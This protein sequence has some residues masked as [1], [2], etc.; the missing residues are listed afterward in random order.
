MMKSRSIRKREKIIKLKE[1]RRHKKK[2][3]SVLLFYFPLH[4]N[5]C[6]RLWFSL[7][8]LFLLYCSDDMIL[9]TC[10]TL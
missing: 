8:E 10:L 5:T 6:I 3:G 4:M 1:S 9:G 7:V 2:A